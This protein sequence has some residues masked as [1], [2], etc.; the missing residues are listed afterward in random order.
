MV[1]RLVDVAC[2]LGTI[3]RALAWHRLFDGNLADLDGSREQNTVRWLCEPLF[4]R[5][6]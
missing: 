1:R 4:I 5:S 6:R 3:G 2:R